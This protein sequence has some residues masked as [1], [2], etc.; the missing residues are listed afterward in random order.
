MTLEGG[1]LTSETETEEKA[2]TRDQRGTTFS[3]SA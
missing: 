2:S 3:S 1:G